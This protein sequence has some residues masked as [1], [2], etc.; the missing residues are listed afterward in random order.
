MSDLNPR[1]GIGDNVQSIDWAGTETARL[2]LDYAYIGKSVEELLSEAAKFEVVTDDDD[3]GKV[4]SLIKRIRDE[5]KR[6]NGLHEIEKAPHFRRGQAVDQFFFGAEDKLL[7]RDKKAKDG[8]ADRL[9]SILTAYDVR[10]LAEEQERRRKEAAEAAR[11]AYAAEQERLRLERE[12][13]E[14]RLAAER[15]RKPE[16]TAAKAEIAEQKADEASAAR[17]DEAVAT[18][19]AEEAYVATLARPADIMRARGDDGT[20]STMGTE[21]FAEVTDRTK[22]DLEKLRSYLPIAAIETA[23]RKYAESVGYSNDAS[24]Q[25]AGARFGKKPK[26]KVY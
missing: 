2:Q 17:V 5:A 15:A 21:K 25:I 1:A 16:T 4:T 18:A 24:V 8:A 3:K 13:E 22:I 9:G 11:I 26:S 6:I 23:L 19:A 12:A 20:L 14:A 7:K 10:K